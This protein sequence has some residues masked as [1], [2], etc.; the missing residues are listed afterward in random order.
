MQSGVTVSGNR[1][2]GTLYK[3]TSGQIV[4]DWGEGY[5][6]GLH[7]TP[8]SD[9]TKTQVGLRPSMGSGP[10]TLEEDGLAMFKLTNISEQ[11]IKVVSTRPGEEKVWF[12]EL[13]GLTLSDS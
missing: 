3:Q 10:A 13:D 1:V 6:I 9:A 12:F 11:R 7:F 2:T 5:F 4:T 8:D